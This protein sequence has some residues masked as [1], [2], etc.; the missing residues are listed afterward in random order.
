MKQSIFYAT[1]AI[2]TMAYINDALAVTYPYTKTTTAT[3]S[4][5]TTTTPTSTTTTPTTKKTVTPTTTTSK[6]TTAAKPAQKTATKPAK[7]AAALPPPKEESFFSNLSYGIMFISQSVDVTNTS[8]A[9]S[10]TSSET[11][12]GIGIYADKFY[13]NTYRFNGTFSYVSYDNFAI[14]SLTAAADYLIPVSSNFALFGGAAAGVAGQKYSD[15][16][17]GDMSMAMVY[18]AQLGGILVMSDN[19]MLELGYRLRLTNLET[20]ITTIPASIDTIDQLNET[21]LSLVISF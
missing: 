20:E 12:S 9:T 18:G 2:V 1:L 11:G 8:G 4:S 6:P 17:F 7:P 14:T 13:K 10:T 3:D 19:L 5:K 21:Y 16:G 15:S